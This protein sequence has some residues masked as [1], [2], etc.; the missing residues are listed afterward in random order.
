MTLRA[1]RLALVAWVAALILPTTALAQSALLS[2]QPIDI[3]ELAR[4]LREE[5][6]AEPAD[7]DAFER[8]HME[9]VE[10]HGPLVER[11]CKALK[12]TEGDFE[13]QRRPS[14]ELQ[15]AQQDLDGALF[16]AITALMPADAAAGIER[17]RVRRELAV[18]ARMSGWF[19]QVTTFDAARSLQWVLRDD[20]ARWAELKPDIDRH[21]LV[22]R[23]V[24]RRVRRSMG[25][26]LECVERTAAAQAAVWSEYR[27]LSE[28]ISDVERNLDQRA[29][30]ADVPLGDSPPA[31]AATEQRGSS[32]G[33]ADPKD[34]LE[35]LWRE[36]RMVLGRA[37]ALHNECWQ[38]TIKAIDGV[39]DQE[40]AL[41]A[42][43]APRLTPLQR[44]SWRRSVANEL[45][46]P[47]DR[48][49]G[50]EQFALALLRAP[51]VDQPLRD[52]ILAALSQWSEED[53][54]AQEA[55]F[56]TAG[57]RVAEQYLWQFGSEEQSPASQAFTE[58]SALREQRAS[59]ARD[60]LQAMVVAQ[61]GDEA[62]GAAMATIEQ[63]AADG[64]E[65][66]LVLGEDP[67]APEVDDVPA[68]SVDS[69]GMQNRSRPTLALLDRFIE[70]CMIPESQA[71]GMR[72]LLAT[73]E[74]IVS[75]I[76]EGELA[77]VRGQEQV[78]LMERIKTMALVD[79][80]AA[81]ET[82]AAHARAAAAKIHDADDAFWTALGELAGEAA[83]DFA[84][85]MRVSAGLSPTDHEWAVVTSPLP[86]DPVRVALGC[87]A[88]DE[89]RRLVLAAAAAA[90]ASEAASRSELSD[91]QDSLG[92]DWLRGSLLWRTRAD[93]S[94]EERAA[95]GE[96]SR[97]RQT[98]L[99]DR[100]RK[101][102]ERRDALRA[103]LALEIGRVVGVKDPWPF[104]RALA[105]QAAPNGFRERHRIMPVLDGLLAQ[106]DLP[107]GV[108]ADVLGLRDDLEPELKRAEER[109]IESM[110]A[111]VGD[112]LKAEEW[113]D[114]AARA[115]AT[116]WIWW[117]RDEVER[118]CAERLRR[119]VPESLLPDS[120]LRAIRDVERGRYGM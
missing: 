18:A 118:R 5:V 23:E 101:A 75:A 112:R 90:E 106:A 24:V 109:L 21:R 38:A 57:E 73:H 89:Q 99:M 65:V 61:V 37:A 107:G 44:M 93:V 64:Q 87:A 55:M 43:L 63:P 36:Q 108:R 77:A 54:A 6:G 46:V 10:R 42:A 2:V 39:I 71:E 92:C 69:I 115:H 20:T 100:Y 120:A 31:D 60:E 1:V 52:R 25:D 11:S 116:L 74:S 76:A 15:S 7:G 97:V 85:A 51:G 40:V 8:V 29:V 35:S 33:D 105:A 111:L 68:D 41:Y 26:A 49:Y 62:A 19:G 81:V 66:E 72:A 3:S 67:E 4:M 70:A 47:T 34:R 30:G 27:E 14:I 28:R 58:G 82:Y 114:R 79:A 119:V 102:I 78:D 45:S 84:P 12:A 56:R 48:G 83:P 17:V 113:V 110:D 13:R 50:V 117:L 91:V 86:G 22:R 94:D 32:D 16:T 80:M 104:R 95:F 103:S 98:E 53:G 88:D 59:R 96:A 9:Y